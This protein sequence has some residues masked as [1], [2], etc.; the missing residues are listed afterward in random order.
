MLATT[1]SMLMAMTAIRVSAPAAEVIM[2]DLYS[3]LQ[4]GPGSTEITSDNGSRNSTVDEDPKWSLA[5]RAGGRMKAFAR[6]GSSLA[7]LIAGELQVGNASYAA[8][9]TD[10]RV[11]LAFAPGITWSCT[12]HTSLLLQGVLGVGLEQFTLGENPGNNRQ[13]LSGQ[14]RHYG[15]RGGVTYPLNK[16]LLLG[17]EVEW[18][19][20]PGNLHGDALDLTVV[21]RGVSGGVILIWRLDHYPT[22]LE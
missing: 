15:I 17:L 5:L 3:G 22:R 21:P 20:A 1:V 12:D 6:A 2:G 10:R 11:G 16:S 9:S 19:K 4:V 18:S 14:Y 7:P 8:G 13:T